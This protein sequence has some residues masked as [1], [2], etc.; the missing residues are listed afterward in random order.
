MGHQLL[1]LD[2]NLKRNSLTKNNQPY[3]KFIEFNIFDRVNNLFNAKDLVLKNKTIPLKISLA[4]YDIDGDIDIF[5]SKWNETEK[6]NY[7][8][9]F[10][11]EDGSFETL[12]IKKDSEAFGQN[13]KILSFDYNNDGYIDVFLFKENKIDILKNIGNYQFETKRVYHLIF[14]NYQMLLFLILILRETLIF[15]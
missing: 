2:I 6:K 11:N 13:K 10:V 3:V 7:Q 12:F 9:M 5:L 8:Y 15:L 1:G 4:D 14:P